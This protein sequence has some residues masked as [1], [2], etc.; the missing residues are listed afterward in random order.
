M[1]SN[2][3]SI[4]IYKLVVLAIYV[5]TVF[6]VGYA[7]GSDIYVPDVYQ[8]IQ[9]AIDA[10][11][12]GDIIILRDGLYRISSGSAF[13][14]IS[15]DI[16][17]RSENGP[18]KCIL[19][20]ETIRGGFFFRS[21]LSRKATISGVTIINCGAGAIRL[22]YTSPTIVNCIISN[23]SLVAT[24][25]AGIHCDN[26]SPLIEN[27]T[28]VNNSSIGS[29]P[30]GGGISCY[31]SSPTIINCT[32]SGNTAVR[33]GG[34]S[35]INSHATILNSIISNNSAEG[36]GGGLYWNH[37]SFPTI[38]NCIIAGNEAA[39]GGGIYARASSPK[40]TNC[41]I[42]MNK[43]DGIRCVGRSNPI[44]T[45]CILWENKHNISKPKWGES[46]QMFPEPI[47]TYSDV[48]NGYPGTGNI[49]TDPS[50][51]DPRNGDF[52]LNADSP[53]I[54]KGS[55]STPDLPRTDLA[56]STRISG[57]IIDMGAYEYQG[58]SSTGEGKPKDK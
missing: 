33:G 32:I 28:I 37:F 30:G 6:H 26:S 29:F 5:F 17:I 12:E 40:I 2:I 41:T 51:V 24:G 45:N 34:I 35:A 23:N 22:W 50:F 52:R 13:G 44:I 9:E 53:C 31:Y 36:L 11:T 8:T 4:G 21:G 38:T 39:M 25:A 18:K 57:E 43:K 48:E 20:G 1:C 10:A 58:V 3:R 42:S 55:N 46:E 56:G 19:D 54:N 15:R 16:T 27:C 47:V 14:I 7:S 49:D